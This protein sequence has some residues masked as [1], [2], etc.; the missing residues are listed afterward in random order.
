MCVHLE[1]RGER[2]LCASRRARTRKCTYA[3][4]A[5]FYYIPHD[6]SCFQREELLLF[7]YCYFAAFLYTDASTGFGWM[8]YA[9]VNIMPGV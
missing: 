8:F 6:F 4:H 1:K 9:C 3:R 7:S 5:F 2:L